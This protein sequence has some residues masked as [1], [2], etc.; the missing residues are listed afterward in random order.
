MV[1]WSKS[2]SIAWIFQWL[3]LGL[4]FRENTGQEVAGVADIWAVS[5]YVDS[6]ESIW[7]S[8]D[9][10]LLQQIDQLIFQWSHWVTE[11]GIDQEDIPQV[12]TGGNCQA[13]GLLDLSVGW[14]AARRLA[15][16][17]LRLGPLGQRAPELETVSNGRAPTTQTKTHHWSFKCLT[18]NKG[19]CWQGPFLQSWTYFMLLLVTA[20]AVIYWVPTTWGQY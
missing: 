6:M 14:M 3:T 17:G 1:S 10:T 9:N 8:C 20:T 15:Q 2:Q 11:E 4:H 7:L 18:I 5:N 13:M 12:W 16:Q 19:Q